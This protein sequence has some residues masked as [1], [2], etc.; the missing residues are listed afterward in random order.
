M[1]LSTRCKSCKSE[2][3]FNSLV[4]DRVELE[5]KKGKE[6]PLT[7]NACHK[8][9]KYHVNDFI[10]HKSQ[11]HKVFMLI[12]VM[13]TIVSLISF[14]LFVGSMGIYFYGSILLAPSA[15]YGLITRQYQV[16]LNSFNRFKV[17]Q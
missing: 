12:I 16:K 15:T 1:K 17:K 10:A 8:K 11:S 4:D 13:V 3:S 7:C 2:I 5:M 14:E 9:D 6:F